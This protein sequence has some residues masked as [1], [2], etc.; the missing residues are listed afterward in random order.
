MS[1]GFADSVSE[2]FEDSVSEGSVDSSVGCS[3]DSSL[4]IVK[5]GRLDD[6]KGSSSMA[7]SF[8]EFC[9]HSFFENIFP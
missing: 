1:E 3:G 9:F 5:R 4:W 8:A 6:D 7:F 2:G